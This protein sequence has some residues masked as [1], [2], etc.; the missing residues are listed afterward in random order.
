VNCVRWAQIDPAGLNGPSV[1][2]VGV[3]GTDGEYRSFPDLA[4]DSCGNMMI[5]YSKTSSGSNPGVYASGR[6]FDGTVHTEIEVKAGEAVYDAFDG[7]PHRW[8]DYTEMTISPDGS[9]FWYLGEYSKNISN[10]NGNWGTWISS[11]SFGCDGGGNPPPVAVIDTPPSCTLLDC[12]FVGSQST[13]DAGIEFY[14]WDF[15]DGNTST[16]ADPSH[17][18]ATEGTYDVSLTVT[19]Y[20]GGSDTASYSLAVDD[21]FNTPPHAVITSIICSD[22]TCDFDGSGSTDSDGSVRG[23]AWDFGDGTNDSGETTTRTYANYGTYTASLVVTD[24]EGD[25]S[26]NDA[27]ETFTLTEPV[28]PQTFSVT[29]VL[30]DTVNRGAGEKSPRATVN[31]ADDQGSAVSS[32]LVTGD[33]SIGNIED[34]GQT[35]TTGSN[36]AAT[37]T[38]SETRKGKLKFTFCVTAVS[39]SADL[40]FDG[41]LPACVSN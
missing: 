22:K 11:F 28:N 39:D 30:V 20:N 18:Y 13:A 12:D 41:N 34:L 2:N 3:I 10:P 6:E 19:D 5:G 24:N 17:T 38:S 16:A 21:G 8:G 7:S 26:T 23:Y 36:G 32:V 29:S 25:P 1:A 40:E 15:G 9:T 27:S 33:F 4:V 31:I 37:L 14:D 35:G